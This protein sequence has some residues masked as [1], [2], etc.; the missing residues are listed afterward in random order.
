MQKDTEKTD[1]I[2]RVDITKQ[3]KG[4]ILAIFP[5]DVQTYKGEIGLYAHVGQHFHGDY[6]VCLKTTRPATESEARD[7][8]TELENCYG[9]NFNIIKRQNYK[10]YLESYYKARGI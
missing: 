1:V 10:K 4:D 5:H 6:N 8:K 3:F 2:F 9:Y 7:L